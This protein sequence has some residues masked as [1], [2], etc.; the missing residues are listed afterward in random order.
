M[1]K[2]CR[3]GMNHLK[4]FFKF[5]VEKMRNLQCG[6]QNIVVLRFLLCFSL[7]LHSG[8]KVLSQLGMW[9]TH[10]RRSWRSINKPVFKIT[11]IR[12][13]LDEFARHLF[14][15]LYAIGSLLDGDSELNITIKCFHFGLPISELTSLKATTPTRRPRSVTYARFKSSSEKSE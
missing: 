13:L 3:G 10:T 9:M 1:M 15:G 14:D 5:E 8:N 11:E 6:C 12:F 2:G 4:Y 7:Q